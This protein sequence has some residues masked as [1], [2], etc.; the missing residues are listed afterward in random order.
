MK[1]ELLKGNLFTSRELFKDK[2]SIDQLQ[3]DL[4]CN[5]L[6]HRNDSYEVKRLSLGTPDVNHVSVSRGFL[7]L[8]TLKL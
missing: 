1:F 3:I 6:H 4:P 5:V 8:F 7:K 2:L